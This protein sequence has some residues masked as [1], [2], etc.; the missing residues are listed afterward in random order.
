MKD[1][2]LGIFQSFD[3]VLK[4]VQELDRGDVDGAGQM[5]T[6]EVVIC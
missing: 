5:P 6:D 3:E 2:A 1:D 4:V